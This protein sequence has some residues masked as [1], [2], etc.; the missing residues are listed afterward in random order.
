MRTEDEVHRM[1]ENTLRDEGEDGLR[2]ARGIAAG[3]AFGLLFWLAVLSVGIRML[4]V[5]R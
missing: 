1:V 3:T 4:G 5:Y 2:A